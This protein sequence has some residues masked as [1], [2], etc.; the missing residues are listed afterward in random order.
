MIG[1]GAITF[2]KFKKSPK[3][4]GYRFPKLSC[5]TGPEIRTLYVS[6]KFTNS[7]SDNGLRGSFFRA[8]ALTPTVMLFFGLFPRI[9]YPFLVGAPDRVSVFEDRSSND[10]KTQ[11]NAFLLSFPSDRLIIPNTLF[12]LFTMKETCLPQVRS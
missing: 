4:E 2:S 3:N 7:V 9:Q 6:P 11:E 1:S 8:F 5:S 12:A 10:L